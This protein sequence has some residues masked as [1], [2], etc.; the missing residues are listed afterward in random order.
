MSFV[1]SLC[2]A[3]SKDIG[4]LHFLDNIINRSGT[5]ALVPVLACV[6][7]G[8]FALSQLINPSCTKPLLPQVIRAPK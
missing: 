7:L 8:T 2:I 1:Y 3:R 4:P 5:V 6:K